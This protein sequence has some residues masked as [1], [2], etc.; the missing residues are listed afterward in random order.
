MSLASLCGSP[1]PQRQPAEATAGPRPSSIPSAILTSW[2]CWPSLACRC[3]CTTH[4]R[5]ATTGCSMKRLTNLAPTTGLRSCGTSSWGRPSSIRALHPPPISISMRNACAISQA[6]S[7]LLAINADRTT[8]YSLAVPIAGER[9]TLTAKDLM[10][11]QVQL[12]DTDLKLGPD[13]ALPELQGTATKSGSVTFAPTSI[14][15]LALPMAH[16]ASCQQ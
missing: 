14:T 15:F 10:D 4:W 3:I 12:N 5:R 16:N 13:D 7:A 1:R 8:A 2:D 11:K 9:Y 6:E